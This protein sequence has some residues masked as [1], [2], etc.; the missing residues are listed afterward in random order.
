VFQDIRLVSNSRHD[1]TS[2]RAVGRVVE[3]AA[4]RRVVMRVD[5]MP[6]VREAAFWSMRVAVRPGSGPAYGSVVLWFED[7]R[8]DRGRGWL[9]ELLGH[10]ANLVV[11]CVR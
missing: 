3:R 9:E 1:A 2:F 4:V 7:L 5:P 8:E 11:N 10:E 6:L